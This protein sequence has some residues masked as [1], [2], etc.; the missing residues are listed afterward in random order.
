MK[1]AV[2]E[3]TVN[4]QN[5]AN[6]RSHKKKKLCQ[7]K[8]KE[9]F[10]WCTLFNVISGNEIIHILMYFIETR[11]LGLEQESAKYGNAT[12][13]KGRTSNKIRSNA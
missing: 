11:Q 8:V 4:S 2:S 10:Y 9:E 5:H 7:F 1:K 12:K 6:I 3:S 13:M